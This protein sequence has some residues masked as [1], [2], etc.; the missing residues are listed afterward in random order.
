[1]PDNAA[2]KLEKHIR[3]MGQLHAVKLEF[4]AL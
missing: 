3:T 4:Y 2:V 1:M